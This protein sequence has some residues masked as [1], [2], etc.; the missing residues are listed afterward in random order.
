MTPSRS[1]KWPGLQ[2]SRKQSAYVTESV[3]EEIAASI[4]EAL[5]GVNDE[6]CVVTGDSVVER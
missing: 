5:G 3:V 2:A 4:N 6:D 1:C